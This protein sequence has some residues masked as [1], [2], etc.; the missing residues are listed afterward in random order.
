MLIKYFSI[1]ILFRLIIILFILGFID[2]SA[3]SQTSKQIYGSVENAIPLNVDNNY[4]R[5]SSY[6]RSKIGFSIGYRNFILPDEKR[7]NFNYGLEILY[8][9]YQDFY[10]F[11]DAKPA[12]DAIRFLNLMVVVGTTIKP[13]KS[14]EALSIGIKGGFGPAIF[15][16]RYIETSSGVG[17][18]YEKR[19]ELTPNRILISASIN[20]ELS[21]KWSI[22]AIT[23]YT[24]N[25][26]STKYSNRLNSQ[27]IGLLT[28][29]RIN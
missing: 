10:D 17:S 9:S 11:D 25:D 24:S 22:G 4:P 1:K 20:W 18:S 28:S 15:D 29:Y 12:R 14:I 19:L 13:I 26:L 27:S 3:F 16:R 7:I 8:R 6:P 5:G 23:T 2:N 21:N